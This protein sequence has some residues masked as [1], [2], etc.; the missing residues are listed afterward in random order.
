MKINC[1]PSAPL[2]PAL[3]TRER[4]P[5]GAHARDA[6]HTHAPSSGSSSGSLSLE[7]RARVRGETL[8]SSIST[9]PHF[10]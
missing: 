5:E 4:E 3:S 9:E 6:K 2:T 10:N 8:A 7:E 1:E